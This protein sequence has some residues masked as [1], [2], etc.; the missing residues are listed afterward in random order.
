VSG[1]RLKILSGLSFSDT[2]RLIG[3][4]KPHRHRYAGHGSLV[5]RLSFLILF[6]LK[7]V[8]FLD[9]QIL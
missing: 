6:I 4:Q 9:T 3:N 2:R 8:F 1:K 7:F 5:I